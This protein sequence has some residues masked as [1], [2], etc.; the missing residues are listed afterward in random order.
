ME[1]GEKKICQKPEEGA[2][3]QEKK[4]YEGTAM[5]S[6]GR[7]RE[8]EA[9]CKKRNKGKQETEIQITAKDRPSDES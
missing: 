2:Q 6:R 9:K 7:I 5:P 4:I 1:L 3:N 8:N